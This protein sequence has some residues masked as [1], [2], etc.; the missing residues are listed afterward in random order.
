MKNQIGKNKNKSFLNPHMAHSVMLSLC[1]IVKNEAAQLRDCLSQVGAVVDEIVVV[2]TGST[3]ETREIAGQMGARVFEFPWVNDFSAARNES[4][5]RANGYYILWLDADDRIDPEELGRIR[6]LK[7][8]L[9]P[10]RLRAYYL[11]IQSASPLDGESSFYQLRLFPN[12]PGV[13]FEGRVHEQV[14]FSL[15]RLGI[16]FKYL[17]I[18]IRHTGYEDP[19]AVKGKYERNWSILEEDLKKHPDNFVHR[20]YAARTLAGMDRYREAIEHIQKI[21]GNPGI[22]KKERTFYLH[23]AIL[24]G[25][26]YLNIHEFSA[27]QALFQRLVIEYPDDPIVHYGL[28]ESFYRAG[29]YEKACSPFWASLTLPLEFSVFPINKDKFVYDQFYNLGHCCQRLGM[30]EQAREVWKSYIKLYPGH[31]QTLELVGLLALESGQL[32]EA[33]DYFQTAIQKGAASDK[34]FANLGLCLRKLGQW[35]EAE[36]ALRQALVVNPVRLEAL[37]NLGLLFYQQ[38]EYPLAL[39]YFNQSLALDPHLL[40]VR[41][42]RSDIFIQSGELEGL[43]KECDEL[44]KILGLERDLTIES[45]Q[46]LGELFFQIAAA[47]DQAGKPTLAIQALH[48]GFSLSPTQATLERIVA[49]AKE[50]G[51]LSSTLQ[52]L[53]NDLSVL[54]K[55]LPNRLTPGFLSTTAR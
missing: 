18:C 14:N 54:K 21:T 26:F 39:D 33:A 34:I 5:R 12:K 6:K 13:H 42:F 38:K 29:E 20:Y 23:A 44:L 52:R 7:A 8:G 36:Q 4:I 51:D 11:L 45:F 41:L 10:D 9:R 43:V 19:R 15:Q 24:L 17:P 16:P 48:V 27:A 35:S 3:D 37:I 30:V 46:D 40:D 25:N 31:C 1:M 22:R 28:G 53:G 50:I 55:A 47:L 32:S 2:D 49:K